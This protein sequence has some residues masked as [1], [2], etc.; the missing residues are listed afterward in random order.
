MKK[1]AAK[2]SGGFIGGLILM[3]TIKQTKYKVFKRVIRFP[4]PAPNPR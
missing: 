1:V 2:F 3:A 4:S